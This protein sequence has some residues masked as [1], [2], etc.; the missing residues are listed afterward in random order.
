MAVTAAGRRLSPAAAFMVLA[1]II[2]L[3]L[4]ASATPSPLYAVYQQRWN[5]STPVLTVIYA[6]YPLGVLVALVLVGTLS[7]Q[8]GRRPVLRWSLVGLLISMGLFVV[9]DSVGWLLAARAVQGLATGAALGAAGAA[10][11]DLHPRGD[12]GQ[13]GLVNGVASTI[14][15]ASGAL[16]SAVLVA[17]APAPRVLPFLVVCA[18]IVIALFAVWAIP[19]SVAVADRP[20]LRPTR[21]SIPEPTRE[22]FTLA[23]LGVLAS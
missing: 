19:E 6:T 2:A 15:I 8:V 22:A 7:D 16:I 10:L 3:A 9:A 18:L 11:I 20:R 1:S 14:G 5:F 23:A 4:Y 17:V 12:A 13:V 21:P